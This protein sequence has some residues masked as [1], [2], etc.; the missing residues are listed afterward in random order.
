MNKK[1]FRKIISLLL[2]AC[3]MFSLTGC[4]SE[5][6]T[7]ADVPETPRI[8]AA[9]V[10]EAGS[11]KREEVYDEDAGSVVTIKASPDGSLT[12][13]VIKR[14]GDD[15]EEDFDTAL[16]PFAVDISYY[17]NGESVT[18]EEIAGASGD[19]RIRFDYKN[20][21]SEK[22]TIDGK[23]LD[24]K[25]PLI[26]V[27]ML[28]LSEDR[29]YDIEVTN[30]GTTEISGSRM[31][32]GMA[33]PGI[34]TLLDRDAVKEELEAKEPSVIIS[35]RP[36][37]L[38]KYVKHNPPLTVNADKCRGCKSCMRIGCPA[39]SMKEGKARIDATLCVG[40]GVCEQL[41]AFGAIGEV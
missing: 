14:A 2:T 36:C 23:T 13:A 33:V 41:C 11:S 30:G 34:S 16:L 25:V 28:A 19:V 3:M 18:A 37:A 8:T 15:M 24:T 12:S 38:L 5:A 21:T 7:D 17:L 22:K 9:P 29:F 39:I 26:F 1:L 31:V 35:R 20:N 6:S 10:K 40:C 27:T 32:Y 4:G